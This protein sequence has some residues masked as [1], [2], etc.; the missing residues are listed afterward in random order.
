[1]A[2][3]PEA[4]YL[5]DTESG[6]VTYDESQHTVINKLEDIYHQLRAEPDLSLIHI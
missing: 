4:L 2:K 3:S 5:A 1:M 6:R